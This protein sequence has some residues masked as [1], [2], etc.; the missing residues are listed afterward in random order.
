MSIMS[1]WFY[2]VTVDGFI[3]LVASISISVIH[4]SFSV[5]SFPLRTLYKSFSIVWTIRSI[6]P[7]CCGLR[8]ILGCHIMMYL[9][10]SS[11]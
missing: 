4:I 3:F 11:L 6:T 5:I 8:S 10:Y 7:L 2:D 1:S 9:F